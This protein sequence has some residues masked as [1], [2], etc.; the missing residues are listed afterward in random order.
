LIAPVIDSGREWLRGVKVAAVAGF[1]VP[2]LL[3]STMYFNGVYWDQA[4]EVTKNMDSPGTLTSVQQY[5]AWNFQPRSSPLMLHVRS[6]PDLFTNTIDRLQGQPGGITPLPVPYDERIHWYSRSIE[7]DMWWAWW[8]STGSSSWAYLYLL[9]PA[10]A[11]A[12]A[13]CLLH[14]LRREAGAVPA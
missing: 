9:V 4:F 1:L 10:A 2:G 14:R 3:G 6:L 8:P 7:L 13:A 5:V 12:G 11:L